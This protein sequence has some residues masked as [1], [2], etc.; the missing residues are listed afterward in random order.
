MKTT[1]V[2]SRSITNRTDEN[3]RK[4]KKQT[5]TIL[6]N[7]RV[8][9]EKDLSRK[10]LAFQQPPFT[11]FYRK[12]RKNGRATYASFVGHALTDGQQHTRAEHYEDV[13]KPP[14]RNPKFVTSIV[15]SDET[16]CVQCGPLT[17]RRSSEKTPKKEHLGISRF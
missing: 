5:S 14:D 7:N 4:Q 10:T 8:V 1:H 2:Q 12:I 11:L 13:R 16:R 15:T 6:R 9:Y 3:V 17:K